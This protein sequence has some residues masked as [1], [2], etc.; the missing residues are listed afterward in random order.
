MTNAFEYISCTNKIHGAELELTLDPKPPVAGQPVT[1]TVSS[2]FNQDI[3][4]GTY[5]YIKL[6]EGTIGKEP[7]ERCVYKQK[8]CI[9]NEA[10]C[11]ISVGKI[12]KPILAHQENTMV[13]WLLL[14]VR[15]IQETLH[16]VPI[17]R[18]IHFEVKYCHFK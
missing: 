4:A 15:V 16:I 18:T 11:P 17:Y 3:T 6:L 7:I 2:D 13:M 10:L 14:A 8:I 5:I 12:V 1:L 9:G